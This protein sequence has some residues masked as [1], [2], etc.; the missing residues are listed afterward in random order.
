MQS[1]RKSK[2][3]NRCESDSDLSQSSH[4]YSSSS[5]SQSPERKGKY[6]GKVSKTTHSKRSKTEKKKDRRSRSREEN[7]KRSKS[8]DRK[9]RSREKERNKRA[10]SQEKTR[11]RSRSKERERSRKSRERDR[12]VKSRSRER[13]KSRR[14]MSEERERNRKSRSRER[15]RNRRSRS[16]NRIRKSKNKRRSRSRERGRDKRSKSRERGRDKKSKSRERGRDKRSKSR[17]RGRDKR[18]KSRERGRDKRSK[19]RERGRDKRNRSLKEGKRY[20]RRRSSES[21]SS[22]RSISRGTKRNR[23]HSSSS[24]DSDYKHSR[25]RYKSKETDRERTRSQR[26]E[27]RETNPCKRSNSTS[28]VENGKVYGNVETSNVLRKTN[29][30][31]VKENIVEKS[32]WDTDSDNADDGKTESTLRPMKKRKRTISELVKEECRMSDDAEANN[33]SSSESEDEEKEL[34]FDWENHRYELNCLFFSDSDIIKRGSE[35]YRD[36]WLFLKKY[37]NIKKQKKIRGMCGGSTSKPVLKD[38]YS[39]VFHL[40]T[41]YE[42]KHSINFMVVTKGISELRQR[43]PPQDLDERKNRLSKKRLKEVQFI[44]QLYSDFTQKQKFEKLKKLRD[45]QSNLPI[46]EY[47]EDIVKKVQENSVVIIAGDTGCGKSTQVPQYLL[48][49]GFSGIACTQPRRIACIS[50]CKRVAYETLNEYGSEVGYQIRFEKSKTDRT[51]IVFLTEGLLLRQ[52]TKDATLSMYDVIILDE[53]HE[54]HLQTD[55]LL[56]VVKCLLLQ[57]STIK[58]ILM[59]ATI[60]IDL[61]NNY[62]MG[63]A[64]VIKVPGRLFPIQ[65]QYFPIPIEEQAS[66]TEK[67]DPAPYVRILNLID[68]KYPEKERGDVLVF[69][70]GM[71]E[72]TTVID[73]LKLYSQQNRRWIILP[74][75]STLA[76]TEQ[77]KV[78]DIPPEGVRKCI[79][80]TNIAETSVTIDGIRF[81]VDSGKV[82]EMSYDS[83]SK[84]RKLKEF[85]ISQ[86]S[87]EQRKGRAGR[88]GPG[89]CFRLYADKKFDELT[90]YSTPE[91]QR[92]PLDSL[93]LQMISMGLPNIR[94]FPFIEPPAAESLEVSLHALKTQAALTDEEKL[95]SVGQLLSQLPVD[96]ALGKMLIMGS[97]FHQVDPVLS[98]AASMSVQSPFTNRAYRDPDCSSSMKNLESDHG[99]AFTLLKAYREWLSIKAEGRENSRKWCRRR[100]LEEQRFYEITKLRH[101]FTQLL[102]DSGLTE[103]TA[104]QTGIGRTSSERAQR[105]GQLKQLR[106]MKKE[107]YQKGPRKAKVLKMYDN[108]GI[109]SDEEDDRTDIKDVDFRIKN[110]YKTLESLCECSTVRT[111]KD[112]VLLKIILC[113]GLYPQ[114]AIADDHNNYKPGSEQLFH[115]YAKPFTILHPNSVFSSQPEVLEVAESDIV[116]APGFNRRNPVSTKHQLLTYVSLLETHKPYLVGCLRVPAAQTIL[117]FAKCVDTNADISVVACDDFLELRFP[118]NVAAQNL[119]FQSILLRN[120][121]KKLLELRIQASKPSITNHDE[122]VASANGM[123]KDLT[124]GL[125]DFYLSEVLY[126]VRRLL[127]ADLKLLH[128]GPGPQDAILCSNPFQPGEPCQPNNIKGGVVLT[129]FLSYNCLLDTECMLTTITSFDSVCPYCDQ[130]LHL[131]TLERLSHMAQC[132]EGQINVVDEEEDHSNDPTKKEYYCPHCEKT[133]WISIRE[134]FRHKQSHVKS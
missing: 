130:E 1:V 123:E 116:D 47:R 91:I 102:A 85:W 20:K 16:S 24:E 11:N 21:D 4:E 128:K 3:V 99:D 35:D 84:M 110:D 58:V 95:T 78:F 98:L 75:H 68:N 63:D 88:T 9:S 115:T 121:W 37:Q 25:S 81:V 23:R 97:L 77:E 31:E 15:D 132:L 36:F 18:S 106:E 103:M 29:L 66:K 107:L 56:G 26:I 94:L 124:A 105:Y 38:A 61:F 6:C 72:I 108:E 28:S 79:V 13:N 111:Y 62:F 8:K 53:I 19:S 2:D 65:L 90:P 60:N 5:S 93:I 45:G 59:S 55:F 114:V 101:Q 127:P 69:L 117:L 10:R 131:S 67:I 44:I 74:L 96:V 120:K 80:S 112:V 129:D 86:A 57:R 82:K 50:L 87:A 71:S 51:K 104:R 113:C 133:L 34:L 17:E 48:A 41:V 126:S 118:D 73:A 122:L 40:P 43:L 54:R 119:V 7:G 49:A 33:S 46:A 89:V 92:V 100:G 30:E 83:Q 70:S 39:Q 125:I 22:E 12:N 52:V 32:R 76:V 64:P 14:S 42:K 134:I 109:M 27:L